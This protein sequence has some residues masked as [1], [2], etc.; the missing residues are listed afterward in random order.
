MGRESDEELSEA[1]V[2]ESSEP[3]TG[4]RW[5][6][7]ISTRDVVHPNENATPNAGNNRT[8]NRQRGFI[9][10]IQH[11]KRHIVIDGFVSFP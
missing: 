9:R 8:H 7:G 3:T 1:D 2:C 10:P 5:P 11:T 6:D 4:G